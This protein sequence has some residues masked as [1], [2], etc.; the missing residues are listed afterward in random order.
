VATNADLFGLT[1]VNPVTGH[2]RALYV[3][4]GSDRQARLMALHD[5]SEVLTVTRSGALEETVSRW[6]FREQAKPVEIRDF[7]SSLVRCL[8]IDRSMIRA[9]EVS[10]PSLKSATLRLSA[11]RMLDTLKGGGDIQEGVKHFTRALPAEHIEMIAAGDAAGDI[12]A[13]FEMLE[14]NVEKSS[15]AIGKVRRALIYPTFI[16]I[17]ALILVIVGCWFL[18]PKIAGIF[19]A[20]HAQLP[21]PTRILVRFSEF[22]QAYPIIGGIIA[23][24]PIILMVNLNRIAQSSITQAVLERVPLLRRLLFK[25]AMG[26]GL[27][28]LAMLLRAHVPAAQSFEIAARVVSHPRISRFFLGIKAELLA[29]A[30]PFEAA[31]ARR[32][33]L[34]VEGFELIQFFGLG[35]KNG[36]LQSILQKLSKVYQK[37][38]DN[39]I[40]SLDKPIQG[41]V[42]ILVG[43]LVGGVA[44]ALFLPLV[45]IN[46]LI[47]PLQ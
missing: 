13:V 26:R 3:F 11:A 1:I 9:L 34:G 17:I 47:A 38:V 14:E 25:S 44:V 33:D 36:D 37:E 28:I 45:E 41:L 24:S 4:A 35:E 40:D 22:L 5:Q 46:T 43:V 32:G 19:L 23:L 29:G 42:V 7:Y 20:S 15:E 10:V 31:N 12:T 21:L 8:S 2:R 39:L 18:V 6:F 16:F 27:S 30:S